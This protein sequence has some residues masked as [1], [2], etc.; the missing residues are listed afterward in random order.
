M[1]EDPD[2]IRR[3][4]EATREQMGRTVDAIS[5]RADVKPRA[6]DTVT[7]K[8]DAIRSKITGAPSR[9]N[10]ATPDA[11]DVKRGA[12]QAVGIAQ[13]NPLGLALGSIAA[14]FVAGMLIPSSRIEDEKLGPVA[15]DVKEA[16]KETGQEALERGRQVAQDVAE[17]ARETVAE[18]GREQGQ[19][20]ASSAQQNVQQAASSAT[21]ASSSV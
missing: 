2:R 3:D 9:L 16:V 19:E 20:L 15:D 18:S 4:I 8:A 5:Y 10:E 7:E 12:R 21:P 14:G 13:E 17:S 11:G 6:K 1:G